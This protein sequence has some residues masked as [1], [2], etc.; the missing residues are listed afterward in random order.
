MRAGFTGKNSIKSERER[1]THC[2]NR[3]LLSFYVNPK[4]MELT[5]ENEQPY[6]LQ[7]TEAE[8]KKNWGEKY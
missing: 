1:I 3:Q 5:A 8:W 2:I 6:F 7:N 4:F